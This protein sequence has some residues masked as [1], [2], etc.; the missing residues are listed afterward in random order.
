[1]ENASKK[2]S[3]PH[4]LIAHPAS[5]PLRKD[6]PARPPLAGYTDHFMPQ[7]RSEG[8]NVRIEYYDSYMADWGLVPFFSR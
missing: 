2:E 8:K 4:N 1:M 6:A 7:V 3:Q 5:A